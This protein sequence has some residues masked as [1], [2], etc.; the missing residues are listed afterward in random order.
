MFVVI[1]AVGSVLDIQEKVGAL[2]STIYVPI[3]R[4]TKAL[5]KD[6]EVIVLKV[7]RSI[8]ASADEPPAKKAKAEGSGCKA[9]AQATSKKGAGKGKRL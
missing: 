6:D 5:A 7:A 9:K 8:N 1:G 3:I 4:N 2:A